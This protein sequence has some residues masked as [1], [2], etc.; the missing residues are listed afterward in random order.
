MSRKRFHFTKLALVMS[1]F[2]TGNTG[3]AMVTYVAKPLNSKWMLVKNTPI[4]CSLVHDIPNYG[5]VAFS[6]NASKE[7]NLGMEVIPYRPNGSTENVS[8]IS[9]PP[10]WMPG[11]AA[12]RMDSLKFYKQFNGYVEGQTAWAVLQE[13]AK[14]RYPTFTYRDWYN[15]NAP[16]QV[17]LSAANFKKTNLAFNQC[18][19]QLLPYSFDDIAFSVL[20]YDKNGK[21]LRTSSKKKLE[22]I[23]QYLKYSDD[24]DLVVVL[25]TY[26]D[27]S[28]PKVVNQQLSE[29]RA[30]NLEAYFSSLGVSKDKIKIEPY[31]E[32]H[33]IASNASE[34]GRSLN[35]RVVISLN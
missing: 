6:A 3:H 30:K 17:S 32:T 2:L 31:G 33:P 29:A 28:G 26:T 19:S 12:Q 15:K 11:V 35:R 27:S 21:N 18:I 25:S 16:I 4:E 10:R 20:N 5:E 14:G 7:I 24:I 13:L 23:A 22:K 1:L 9:M 8:L 34:M